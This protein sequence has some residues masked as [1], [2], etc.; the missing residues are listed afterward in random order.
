M[1]QMANILLGDLRRQAAEERLARK[2]TLRQRVVHLGR[3][4]VEVRTTDRTAA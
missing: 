3:R 2:A 4:R 1:I